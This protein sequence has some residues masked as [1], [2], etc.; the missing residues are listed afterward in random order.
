MAAG[1]IPALGNNV[2]TNNFGMKTDSRGESGADQETPAWQG[3]AEQYMWLGSHK[4][5]L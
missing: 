3:S 4:A 5:S 2:L 1:D